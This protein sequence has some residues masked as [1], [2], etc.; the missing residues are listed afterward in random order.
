MSRVT[1]QSPGP[2]VGHGIGGERHA[3]VEVP[4]RGNI[5]QWQTLGTSLSLSLS[6]SIYYY[7]STKLKLETV[8][9]NFRDV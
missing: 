7:I 8:E 4:L 9:T 5:L 2:R 6:L 1:S 3:V